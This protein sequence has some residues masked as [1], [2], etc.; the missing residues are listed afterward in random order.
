MYCHCLIVQIC[1]GYLAKAGIS[2]LVTKA[3]RAGV[4]ATQ[5]FADGVLQSIQVRTSFTMRVLIPLLVAICDSI[6]SIMYM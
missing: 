5:R 1:Y 6:L 4:D 2:R 3:P